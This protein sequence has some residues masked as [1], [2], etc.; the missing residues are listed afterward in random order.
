RR[1]TFKLLILAGVVAFAIMYGMEL[2]SSGI[3]TVYGPMDSPAVRQDPAA[4]GGNDWSL[5]TRQTDRSATGTTTTDQ[6]IPYDWGTQNETAIPR[7]DHKP[8]VD[9]ISGKTA[10]VLHGLSSGG[11]RFVVTLFDKMTGS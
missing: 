11:I 4:G 10:E 2:A 3:S 1:D 9:R 5:P 8:I 6:T 7:N